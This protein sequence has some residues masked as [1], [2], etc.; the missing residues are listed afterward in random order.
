M[1]AT[2]PELPE[3]PKSKAPLYAGIAIVAAA[4]VAAGAIFLPSL[5]GGGNDDGN[6]SETTDLRVVKLGTT[7]ASQGQWA[8]LKEL[9]VAEGI[10]LQLSQYAE[11]PLPNPALA[12]G[13]DDLNAFQHFLYLAAHNNAT[14]DNLQ[15]I[16]TSYVVPL[17]LYGDASRY[18]TLD[19][20]P[21]GATVAIPDDATNGARALYVLEDAGLI[22]LKS[23][24][25]ALPSA[26]DV[27]QANS[28]VTISPV[29][30]STT[31]QAL[32]DPQIGLAVIN[33]NFAVDNGLLNN[34]EFPVLHQVD[35]QGPSNLP[36]WN[37]IVAR[38]GEVNDPDLIKVAELL[39]HPDVV[40]VI[41]EEG[42][43]TTFVINYTDRVKLR[44]F[45]AEIE[46]G[47][48]PTP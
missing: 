20:I 25:P 4:A 45:Q 29:A 13:E 9:L 44:E 37:I 26:L 22:T 41:V 23:D 1:S 27:D 12:S 46:A 3:K 38:P 2:T 36:F 32:R 42:G 24:H 5:L 35:P 28:R 48:W 33:N 30:A 16:A 31:A 21:Q 19:A 40:K 8:V 18:P 10:D 17:P 47:G 43:G 7:D 39:H 14:G 15:P 6:A 11:Y 34:A